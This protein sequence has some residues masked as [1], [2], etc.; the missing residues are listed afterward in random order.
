MARLF[1]Q[2]EVTTPS[3][4]TEK[5]AFG[6]ELTPTSNITWTN[7]LAWLN[8]VLSFLKISNNLSDVG[9]VTT[10]QDNLNVYSKTF[11]DNEL[12]L[13]ADTSNVIEKDSTVVYTPTQ[14]YHPTN[15]TYVDNKIINT[16]GELVFSAHIDYGNGAID[17]TTYFNKN[18]FIFSAQVVGE[19]LQLYLS[20]SDTNWPTHLE[21]Q[22]TSN[23]DAGSKNRNPH[24]FYQS[25]SFI[26]GV[27]VD[28]SGNNDDVG[29]IWIRIYD[30]S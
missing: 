7:F 13:K 11:I 10:A 14:D 9:D 4:L 24:F 18:G 26:S 20:N 1:E 30:W 2:G 21:I 17:R 27:L 3:D 15:K 22:A 16:V 12:G 29:S 6:K 25:D 23:P 19:V 8:S 5:I 28:S